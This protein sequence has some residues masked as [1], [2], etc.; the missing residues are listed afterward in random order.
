MIDVTL[1][2]T[3]AAAPLPGRA[4]ACAALSCGG[5]TL[6]FDCGEGTQNALRNARVSP[7]SIDVICLTHFHG[8]HIFGLPGLLQSMALHSRTRPVTLVVPHEDDPCLPALLTLA[9]PLTFALRVVTLPPEGMPLRE[10]IP[11]F[12]MDALLSPIVTQHRVPSAGY[13]FTLLHAGRFLV[14]KARV[15]GVPQSLWG[16]LQRGETVTADGRTITP[17]EVLGAPRQPLTVVYTGDTRPCDAVR[18]A[19]RNADLLIMEATYG[20]DAHEAQAVQYGHST[21]SAAA[22]LAAEAGVKRLWLTHYS[23]MI[24]DPAMYLP[25]AQAYFPQTVYG[26]DGLSTTLSYAD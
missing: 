23:G 14:E 7:M 11:G 25:N 1:V 2:G 16:R 22:L 21:F 5:R 19:A 10:L 15:L 9:L 13:R 24:A 8:D 12:R 6:L 3:A 20:E 4:L 18:D 17:A 26:C